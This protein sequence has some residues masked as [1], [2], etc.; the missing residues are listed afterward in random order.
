MTRLVLVLGDQ[1]TD[2]LSAMRKAD[3]STDVIVMAEA[4]EEATYV[5]HHAKKIAF[6]FSAMRH[7]ADE[8]R[9][10]GIEVSVPPLRPDYDVLVSG[11]SNGESF[12]FPTTSSMPAVPGPSP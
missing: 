5:R 9:D 1:L 11:C 10:A 2:R 12:T 8:L 7:F 6:I 4:M 3:K